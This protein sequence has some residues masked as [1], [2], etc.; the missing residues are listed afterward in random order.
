MILMEIFFIIFLILISS[1][2][3]K[4]YIP[5]LKL[6]KFI[7]EYNSSIKSLSLINKKPSD[8]NQ[9]FDKITFSGLKLILRLFIL[10]IPFLLIFFCF[11]RISITNSEVSLLLSCIPYLLILRNLK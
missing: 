2:F 8:L 3:L 6:K 11:Q 4:V 10:L 7:N 9:I 5:K 1:F